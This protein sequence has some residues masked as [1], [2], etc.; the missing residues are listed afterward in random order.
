ME[1]VVTYL[2][3]RCGGVLTHGGLEPSGVVAVVG[4]PHSVGQ[5]ETDSL[6][7]ARFVLG[8]GVSFSRVVGP[9]VGG[10]A[11][12]GLQGHGGGVRRGADHVV[13]AHGVVRR[14]PERS[15][16][17]ESGGGLH[18]RTEAEYPR[19]ALECLSRVVVTALS[20]GHPSR[21][22]A[23]KRAIESS[24]SSGSM[25][26]SILGVPNN[27]NL[28]GSDASISSPVEIPGLKKTAAKNTVT[29]SGKL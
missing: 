5:W 22:H 23:D 6:G 14:T 24:K 7:V 8:C 16:F 19:H 26:N 3:V 2:C 1:E 17:G 13:D 20:D 21:T 12:A 25:R 29:P 15:S 27:D 18:K 4:P 28:V 9:K 10:V 11:S